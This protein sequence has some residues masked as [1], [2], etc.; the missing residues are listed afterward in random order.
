MRGHR[1]RDDLVKSN[2]NDSDCLINL[3]RWNFNVH[4]IL[5]E[6][7]GTYVAGLTDFHLN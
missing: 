2:L 6:Q 4:Y 5:F 3:I 1:S 7:V